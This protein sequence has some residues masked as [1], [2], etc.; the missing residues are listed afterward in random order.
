MAT[1]M[2]R[3]AAI[4]HLG[5]LASPHIVSSHVL[6]GPGKIAPSDTVN[7]ALVGAGG[8]GLQ[9]MRSLMA[10]P[11]VRI[12]AIADPARRWDLSNF[13]Y[14]GSAGSDVAIEM[15]AAQHRQHGSSPF[16]PPLVFRDHREL[17]DASEGL[18]DAVLCATP[19]HLH[20]KV[21]LDA[22]TAG[23][24]VYCEKPLTHNVA[25]SRA[26]FAA[27]DAHPVAT[28]MG[29]QGH[30]KDT[31]RQTCEWIWA[32]AIGTVREVHA[33]VPATRWNPGLMHP[34]TEPESPPADLD[35]DLWCGPRE[36]VPYHSAYAPVAWRDFWQ[37]GCGA[38]GDFG[39]HD[40]D[41]AVWALQLSTPT[42]IEIR[43]AGITDDA[44]IP[45]GEQ[46]VFEF[47]G[48][49]IN[50]PGKPTGPVQVHWYSG[51]L[52]PP[53]PDGLPAND[54]LPARGVM[55]VGSDGFMVCGGAGGT[56]TLYPESRRDE[57]EVPEPSIPRSAGHHRDWVDAIR[58][59]KP[60]SSHF[61]VAAALNEITLLGVAA[62]RAQR[63][64]RYD[65]ANMRFI[66]DEDATKLLSGNYRSGWTLPT[67]E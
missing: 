34:P 64:L 10:I 49:S 66:D 21:T 55:F 18:F 22:M 28:Q 5:A 50:G 41:S 53:R 4:A 7:V 56:P 39:C 15:L 1:P 30:S 19:D 54:K 38:M 52:R 24:A 37:F 62:V 44:M 16:E 27:L 60:A 31:I 57:F 40:L 35:W 25:E 12:T 26:V 8:R 6:G 29:N 45:F 58:G 46:G 47:A 67:I 61:G 48:A 2:N 13:Y 42:A 63:R 36:M 11:G 3:R 51:G 9:N 32:G 33:W 20:A 65:P 14:G 17:M 43:A 59:G 23:K